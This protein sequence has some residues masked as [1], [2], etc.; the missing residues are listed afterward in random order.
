MCKICT[1]PGR[2]S[3]IDIGLAALALLIAES[4]P[5][6]KDT[7]IRLVMNMLAIQSDP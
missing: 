7:M 3:L 6:H 4:D 1:L 5:T 2:T